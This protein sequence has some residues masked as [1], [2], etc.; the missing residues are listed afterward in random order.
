MS[1]YHRPTRLADALV[2]LAEGQTRVLAGGTD[3]YPGAGSVL[4]GDVVDVTAVAEIGRITRDDAGLRIGAV[5]TW[6]AIAA[7]DLPPA[8]AALQQAALQI[9]G[10]QIQNAGTVGGNL[11][12]GSPAADGVPPLLVLDAEVEIA[13]P[14]GLRRM[15][16][17]GFVTGPRRVALE[18][19][20]VLVAVVVPNRT[21]AGRSVFEK[22][23]ARRHLVISIAMV[24]ARIVVSDGRVAEV[25]LA[26]GSCSGTAR[27]LPLVEA[28]LH[29]AVI[30]TLGA[31]V[32]PADVAASL[33]PIDDIRATAGYRLEAATAL[34]RRAVET[35]G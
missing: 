31:R 15:P 19:G 29:A 6:A 5:V 28:A 14:C 10:R 25:A 27:R 35:L 4:A 21:L 18:P 17:S 8:L 20:E 11:C 2:L 32:T 34:V 16:L 13:G 22:L 23:G 30:G 9:G 24:A 7:A 12:N 26:V 1:A 3:L 33:A